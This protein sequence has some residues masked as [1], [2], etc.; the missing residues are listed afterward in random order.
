M[1][2]LVM[3]AMATSFMFSI[4]VM[5]QTSVLSKVKDN[6]EIKQAETNVAASAKARAE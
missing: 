1:K 3:I 6:K 4:T 5:A 2:K